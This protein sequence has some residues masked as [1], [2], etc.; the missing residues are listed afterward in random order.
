MSQI[1]NARTPAPATRW[2]LALILMLGAGLRLYELGGPSFWNDELS[3][4]QR[5]SY[6]S[7]ARVFSACDTDDVHPPGYYMLLYFVQRLGDSEGWLRLPSALAGIANLGAIF[8]LGRRMWGDREGLVAAGLMAV[9]WM[10]VRYAQEARAYAGLMLFSTLL[11]LALSSL[12]RQVDEQE[13][14]RVKE[15][16]GYLLAATVL[17]WL[18]YFGLFLAGLCTL[19]ALAYAAGRRRMHRAL[20]RLLAMAGVQGLLYLPWLGAM[21]TDLTRSGWRPDGSERSGEPF[22]SLYLHFL[23]NNQRWLLVTVGVLVAAALL[24][25]GL[26]RMRG[27]PLG[28]S[29]RSGWGL[30]LLWIAVPAGI[31]WCKDQVSTPVAT[32]RNLLICAPPIY[33]LVARAL[34]A[35]PLPRRLHAGTGFALVGSAFF[36]FLSTGYYTSPHRHQ[37]REAVAEVVAGTEDPSRAAVLVS[38]TP[39]FYNYYFQHLGS[40]LRV[41]LKAAGEADIGKLEALISGYEV[42]TIWWIR[43]RGRAAIPDRVLGELGYT[44]VSSHRW[45]GEIVDAWQRSADETPRRARKRG[46]HRGAL[47]SAAKK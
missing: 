7:L 3:S 18:H 23:F 25:A 34:F 19:G 12:L 40:E 36:G 4:W 43:T 30:M 5:S 24:R 2:L 44:R 8:A 35:L 9:L 46:A 38:A 20:P 42:E 17:A 13:R 29:T 6:G 21:W 47:A 10:P 45:A 27:E 22:A 32:L 39:G 41:D 31:V 33:L 28:F 14:P 15:M 1:A 16:T 11:V 37:V 26:A